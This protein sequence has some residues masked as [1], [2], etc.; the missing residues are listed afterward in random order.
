MAEYQNKIDLIKFQYFFDSRI[1]DFFGLDWCNWEGG[2]IS[3]GDI[4]R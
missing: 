4:E 2:A 3:K 1:I